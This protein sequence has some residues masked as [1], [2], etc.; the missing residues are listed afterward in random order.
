MSLFHLGAFD[1]PEQGEFT[2]QSMSWKPMKLAFGLV[3]RFKAPEPRGMMGIEEKKAQAVRVRALG[4]PEFAASV[5]S[6]NF[7]I[8]PQ[9][10]RGELGKS[11]GLEEPPS[12]YEVATVVLEDATLLRGTDAQALEKSCLLWYLGGLNPEVL[13]MLVPEWED[14]CERILAGLM[15][16]NWFALW[17]LGTDL[18]PLVTSR[19]RA[20]A[21]LY[22][23]GGEELRDLRKE[24]RES[25]LA[26]TSLTLGKRPAPVARPLYI[27]GTPPVWKSYAER[28]EKRTL[29]DQKMLKSFRDKAC[30]I[31]G[32]EF[33]LEPVRDEHKGSTDV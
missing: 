28:R 13:D 9:E 26:S 29:W 3:N 4:C 1:S 8:A 10:W 7:G 18:T 25:A 16:N 31:L 17:A 27:R 33:E 2:I 5:W 32:E 11:F 22:R 6:E 30:A 19:A 23:G 24:M 12:P 20:R 21:L 14:G 15:T